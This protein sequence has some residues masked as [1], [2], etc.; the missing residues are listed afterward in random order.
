[1]GRVGRLA[2]LRLAR[3]RRLVKHQIHCLQQL[4]V[5]RHLLARLEQNDIAHDHLTAR[6]LMHIAVTNHLDGRIV[7]HLVEAAEG[8]LVLPL[9]D[10]AHTR[11]E[12]HSDGDTYRLEI[13]R[14]TRLAAPDALIE[15][16]G[17]REQQRHEQN[18]DKRIHL[19]AAASLVVMAAEERHEI[20]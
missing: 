1:M 10:V 8:L 11:G 5:G 13:R 15:R 14:D 16:N 3:E 6:H 9:K 19:E 4:S 2:A 17:R 20:G 12:Q 7:I 18:G